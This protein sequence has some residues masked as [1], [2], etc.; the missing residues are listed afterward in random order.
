MSGNGIKITMRS[1]SSQSE[2]AIDKLEAKI[3]KLE[4]VIAKMTGTSTASGKKLGD[5]WT[6]AK[7]DVDKYTKA[8][9]DATTGQARLAASADLANAKLKFASADLKYKR[10]AG[11][12]KVVVPPPPLGSLASLKSERDNA[13]QIAETA[14]S[15][16]EFEKAA[17]HVRTL[18]AEI[19]R[20]QGVLSGKATKPAKLIS[21]VDISSVE[22]LTQKLKYLEKQM[23]KAGAGTAEFKRLT[24][25]VAKTKAQLAALGSEAEKASAALS[26][27]ATAPAGSFARLDYELKKAKADIQMLTFGTQEYISKSM[28]VGRIEEHWKRVDAAM[29]RTVKTQK[30]MSSISGT[31]IG[32]ATTLASTYLGMHQVVQMMTTEWKKQRDLQLAIAAEGRSLEDEIVQQIPNIG[33]ENMANVKKFAIDGAGDVLAKPQKTMSLVGAAMSTGVDDVEDAK[34]LAA[35]ALRMNAGNA[36]LAKEMMMAGIAT[37]KI[38]GTKDYQGAMGQVRSMSA[39]S[40]SVDE[41]E[42]LN[43]AT[44][45]MASLTRNR[46]NTDGMSTERAWEM[47]TIAGRIKFDKEGST[48]ANA[49]QSVMDYMDDVQ[50]REKRKLRSGAVSKIDKKDIDAFNAARD[51]DEKFRMATENPEIR[52]QILESQKKGGGRNLFLA[53]T[54]GDKDIVDLVSQVEKAVL[55]IKEGGDE[56]KKVVDAI[57]SLVPNLVAGQKVVAG[58]AKALIGD[59]KTVTKATARAIYDTVWN[60]GQIGD[61]KVEP[62]NLTGWDMGERFQMADNMRATR[63]AR[64][65]GR[66]NDGGNDSTDMR[67][68]L[69]RKAA[70][71]RT[72]GNTVAAQQLQSRS[73]AINGLILEE[74]K[75][76][77]AQVAG[78]K[79]P[80]PAR[81]AQAPPVVRA[82]VAPGAV[83]P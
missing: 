48:S 19:Q 50:L 35:A 23:S 75:R 41:D 67:D 5:S 33:L 15:F 32:Q 43:N 14:T 37:A 18:T 73:D 66:I 1:D 55:S 57:P 25:E 2:I 83:A 82:P 49:M 61:Q 11:E 22:G 74:L 71:E 76:L 69:A 45:A 6:N 7:R 10:Y 51:P 79:A 8:L 3:A 42:F 65:A 70:F 56:F 63:W 27:G 64:G 77:N 16:Q 21:A 9:K 24:G 39:V 29:N 62:V 30:G 60:G 59:E 53:L 81:P 44:G 80:P 17:A 28:Q 47:L 4:G 34:K 68:A 72:Q 31:L 12:A 46:R 40:Q 52:N 26:K 78:N 54:S 20:Y 13:R 58:D 38:S 36:E